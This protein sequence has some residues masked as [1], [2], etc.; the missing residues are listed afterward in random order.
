MDEPD[1]ASSAADPADG[2]ELLRRALYSRWQE[3]PAS[4]LTARQVEMRRLADTM[5][6]IMDR[7][8]R[9]AA[10]TA[11]IIEAADQL[12]RLAEGF[13][14]L[15]PG[16]VYEGFAETAN[17]GADPTASF[18]F[19][20]FIGRANPLAPPIRLE[21]VD[22]TVQGR[23]VFSAAYEGAPGCLHGGYIAG[24][25]DEVLGATQSLAGAP[26]MTGTLTVRFRSPTPLH[27]EL[28]FV[29]E[30]L[31]VE[32]RKIFT[33]ATLH[34]GN[35]LCAEAEGIF[36]SVPPALFAELLAQRA[37]SEAERLT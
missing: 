9:T 23:A 14:G 7:L 32:G 34:A 2:A 5:R 16:T 36:I 1:G 19:S 29:G 13:G 33:A 3:V 10:P 22:G 6:S 21:E 4:Q 30:L 26:G 25:F 28:R 11:Q 12:A 24:A 8:V 18:E 37:A 17:A 15:P 20:P 35:R 31:R 27:T